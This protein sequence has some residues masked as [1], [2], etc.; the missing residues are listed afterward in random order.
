MAQRC[1]FAADIAT[2]TVLCFIER[3]LWRHRKA[4]TQSISTKFFYSQRNSPLMET[5]IEVIVILKSFVASVPLVLGGNVC[6]WRFLNQKHA[7]G[8]YVLRNI[9]KETCEFIFWPVFGI[10]QTKSQRCVLPPKQLKRSHHRCSRIVQTS[11]LLLETRLLE[12]RL[13]ET[14]LL[15]TR[16]LET[17]CLYVHSPTSTIGNKFSRRHCL[18]CVQ[19]RQ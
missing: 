15:E 10:F 12:T 4:G 14:R 9:Y 19:D 18:M 6:I 3:E 11:P 7:I 17:R 13:L 8:T 2:F 5:S 16:L 1:V